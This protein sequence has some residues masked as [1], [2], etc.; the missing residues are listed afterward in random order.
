MIM[1]DLK[2]VVILDCGD[3]TPYKGLSNDTRTTYGTVV[4]IACI[5]GTPVT[6]NSTIICQSDGTWSENPVCD[7]LG[8]FYSSQAVSLRMQCSVI[9]IFQFRMS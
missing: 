3:P 7:D 8:K 4:S 9:P 1:L 6:G 2:G 5:D